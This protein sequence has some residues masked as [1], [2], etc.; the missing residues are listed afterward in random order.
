MQR[1]LWSTGSQQLI[2]QS[3]AEFVLT[4]GVLVF[5]HFLGQPL[6][7]IL[8]VW[9]SRVSQTVQG[10]GAEHPMPPSIKVV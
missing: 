10:S 4:T 9:K 6:V 7:Q 1:K 2:I 3:F 8:L 5:G